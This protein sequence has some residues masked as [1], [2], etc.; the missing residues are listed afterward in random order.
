MWRKRL[1][2]GINHYNNFRKWFGII[3][4]SWKQ[5]RLNVVAGSV[6]TASISSQAL[7]AFPYT[8]TQLPRASTCTFAEGTP[9]DC[10]NPLLLCMWWAESACK[11]SQGQPF[12]NEWF[13]LK[14]TNSP[15]FLTL[16]AGIILKCIS[17]PSIFLW[18]YAP[19]TLC[20]NWLEN[21]SHLG[22][23]FSPH[24]FCPCISQICHMCSIFITG[25]SSGWW[26]GGSP[27]QQLVSGNRS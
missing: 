4:Q 26:R 17:P 18:N 21:T 9:S 11:S 14:N 13:C 12:A 27:N 6:W 1:L 25:S 16:F 2:I 23:F 19:V 8:P 20:G 15:S 22:S 5:T 10:W 7:L 3:F 24:H